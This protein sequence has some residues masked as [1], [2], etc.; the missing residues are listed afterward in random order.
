MM[1]MMMMICICYMVIINTQWL[2]CY[3]STSLI[4]SRFKMKCI[5][6]RE[7]R[8]LDADTGIYIIIIIIYKIINEK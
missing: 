6:A 4:E 7:Y 1:M 3:R 5:Y 2:L 8:I